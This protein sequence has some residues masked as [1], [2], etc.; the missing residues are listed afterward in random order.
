MQEIPGGKVD[1]TDETILHAA[2]R[3][4]QEE[5]G[6]GAIRVVRK[7]AQLTF[8][9]GRPGREQ[10]TWL[11]LAFEMEVDNID[12]TLDPTE[13]QSFLYATEEEVIAGVVGDIKMAYMS[14][15]SKAVKLEAFR[16]RREA[17]ALQD[18]R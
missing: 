3:E 4:L 8:L 9:D 17:L 18:A 15:Q 14:P 5:A 6:L 13:H 7:V 16:L 12:V 2:A 11:K 10:K 1:D